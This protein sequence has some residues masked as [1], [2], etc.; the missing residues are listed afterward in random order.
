VAPLSFG[1]ERLWFMHEL[2]PDT[3]A[4]TIQAAVR[5]R[6]DLDE[7]ALRESLRRV[8]D[9]HDVLRT[10]FDVVEGR[11]S[12]IIGLAAGFDLDVVDCSG[13]PEAQED[14]RAIAREIERDA[15]R[16]FDLQNGPLL[17]GTLLRLRAND[18]VLVLTMHHIVSDGWS[19]G[20]L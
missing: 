11:P 3:C 5:I 20:V 6:G 13:S 16:P 12:Q 15:L 2:Q 9:R 14:K 4:Y 19:I 17:R 1:Q 8:V 18:R 7:G 10:T